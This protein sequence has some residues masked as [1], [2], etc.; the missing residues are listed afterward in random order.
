MVQIIIPAG[1]LAQPAEHLEHNRLSR[2]VYA[3][4]RRLLAPGI[5]QIIRDRQIA[6]GLFFFADT[7]N[8]PNH[9][10]LALHINRPVAVVVENIDRF[11]ALLTLKQQVC[12]ANDCLALGRNNLKRRDPVNINIW[13]K[14]DVASRARADIIHVKRSGIVGNRLTNN[15]VGLGQLAAGF[16]FVK[17]SPNTA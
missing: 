5:G 13:H 3:I 4:K 8:R 14:N 6:V 16:V 15:D 7:V 17:R 2:V 1:F 12:A 10:L 9:P 11:A